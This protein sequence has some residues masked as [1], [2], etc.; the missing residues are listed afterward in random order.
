MNQL[1][2]VQQ[3]FP[4]IWMP[5]GRLPL[6]RP[7]QLVHQV[8]MQQSQLAAVD[9]A[10]D[11]VGSLEETVEAP[12][13]KVRR[14]APASTQP[15]PSQPAP[16]R[17]HSAQITPAARPQPT[18]LSVSAPPVFHL[19]ATMMDDEWGLV[20]NLPPQQGGLPGDDYLMLSN[21]IGAFRKHRNRTQQHIDFDFFRWPPSRGLAKSLDT[22]AMGLNALKGFLH[23]M[24]NKRKCSW[25]VLDAEFAR[26]CF[27]QPELTDF[28]VLPKDRHYLLVGPGLAA[29]QADPALKKQLWLQITSLL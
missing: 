28:A 1:D 4:R 15:K 20:V 9:P 26:F 10:F 19:T 23:K 29:L 2:L 12:A 27:Q 11:P 8:S 16:S 14:Q 25:I 18:E 17:S 13:A 24:A 22:S 3:L 5:K 21:F 7:S 6:G